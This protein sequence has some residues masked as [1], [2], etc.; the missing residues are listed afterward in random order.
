M[1]DRWIHLTADTCTTAAG[2]TVEPFYVLH[3]PDWVC[4]LALTDDGQV[5]LVDE[6]HHGA[7]VVL[8]GFPGG[9]IEPGE[10]AVAAALRELA[11]EMGYVSD[12]AV[13]AGSSYV[14]WGNR[15]CRPRDGA[16]PRA[17][18]DG[19]VVFRRLEDVLAD[20][21]QQAF[22]AALLWHAR[23]ALAS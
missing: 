16:G 4:V 22:H 8:A 7:R 20:P 19:D 18:E 13:E 1:H 12:D 11:E 14:N 3:H 17:G 5:V 9:A 15:G 6:Y 21:P 2:T 10:D 23:S